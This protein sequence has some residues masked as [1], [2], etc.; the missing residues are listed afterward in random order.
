MRTTLILP[1]GLVEAAR[2]AIGFTSKTDTV[3]FA[4]REVVRRSRVQD[5]KQLIGT[6]SYDF[7]PAELRRKDRLRVK[8]V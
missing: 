7:D 8:R 3:T 5:L 4:L 6:V 2:D 1:D